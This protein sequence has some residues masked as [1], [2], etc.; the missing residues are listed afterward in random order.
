LQ[1]VQSRVQ[2]EDRSGVGI[3]LNLGLVQ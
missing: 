1:T 3:D 2:L